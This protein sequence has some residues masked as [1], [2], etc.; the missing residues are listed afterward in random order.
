LKSDAASEQLRA[1]VIE[2]LK[3]E[4]TATLIYSNEDLTEHV[5]E[6]IIRF[7]TER[8]MEELGISYTEAFSLAREYVEANFVEA[9]TIMAAEANAGEVERLYNYVKDFLIDETFDDLFETLIDTMFDQVFELIAV[10][11]AA[12]VAL[13]D[14]AIGIILGADIEILNDAILIGGLT[15]EFTVESGNIVVFDAGTLDE[16]VVTFE[17]GKMNFM[18]EILGIELAISIA[19]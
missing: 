3:E 10:E 15:F 8:F 1:L 9:F 19:A 17:N 12:Y 7:F 6:T 2:S 14:T 18:I 16:L 5:S 13:I 4:A 11:F